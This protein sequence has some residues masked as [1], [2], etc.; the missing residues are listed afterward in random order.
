[1]TIQRSSQN[2]RNLTLL[3]EFPRVLSWAHRP[4]NDNT[5]LFSYYYM[6]KLLCSPESFLIT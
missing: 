1:M 6:L 3:R 2:F 5:H 4:H